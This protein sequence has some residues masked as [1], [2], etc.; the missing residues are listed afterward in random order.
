V[1]AFWTAAILRHG[2]YAG[3][4]LEAHLAIPALSPERFSAW[5]R[6]FA[7]TI[8]ARRPPLSPSQSTL[9]MTL[10][11]RMANRIMAAASITRPR[12]RARSRGCNPV[13]WR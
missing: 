8:A 6:L 13:F 11:G 3:R 9:F 4:P 1:K 5:L 10:A 12:G 2:G 7:Q